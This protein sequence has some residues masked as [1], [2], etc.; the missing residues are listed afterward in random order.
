VNSSTNQGVRGRMR[1]GF[2]GKYFGDAAPSQCFGSNR[3]G[4]FYRR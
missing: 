2:M 3:S 1:L 4:F